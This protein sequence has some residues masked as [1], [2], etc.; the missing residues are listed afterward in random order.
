VR[1]FASPEFWKR[2]QQLTK[3]VQSQA[4]KAFVL[5][6]AN[7]RHPSLRF[8]KK[9]KGWSARVSRGCRVLAKERA[10]GLVWFWIGPHDEYL[11]LIRSL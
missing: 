7:P 9:G 4:D 11:Q 2:Y 10:E 6:K 1:H 5:L 8:E 3:E